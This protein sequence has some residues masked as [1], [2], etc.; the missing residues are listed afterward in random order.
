MSNYKEMVIVVDGLV[1]QFITSEYTTVAAVNGVSFS[2]PREKMI[3]IKGPSGCGKTT[4]LNLLGALDKPTAGNIV[5]DG[6]KVSE[7]YGV[8]ESEY[9]LRKVGF[10]FQYYYLIAN[11][12]ALENVMLPMDLRGMKRKEQEAGA[13]RLLERVGIDASHQD[14]RPTRLSGGEQQRVAIARALANGPAII[15]ADEPTGNLDSKTGKRIIELLYS[16]TTKE[17]R[18]VI[19]ATHDADIAARADI[20]LEMKDAKLIS[21]T[22][23]N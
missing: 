11:L 22:D 14:R 3:A 18:T 21:Q 15:L 19:V 5:V 23:A 17:G 7:L 9:R 6:I 1:K 8:N 10:V 12:T 20:V 2:L 16:L 13:R 4:L